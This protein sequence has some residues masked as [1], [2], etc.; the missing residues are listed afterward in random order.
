MIH[1]TNGHKFSQLETMCSHME[2]KKNGH[3]ESTAGHVPYDITRTLVATRLTREPWSSNPMSAPHRVTETVFGQNS[4]PYNCFAS[5][6]S[7][8]KMRN[9]VTHRI[10]F[11]I[12]RLVQHRR[13]LPLIIL[14]RSVDLWRSTVASSRPTNQSRFHRRPRPRLKGDAS[15]TPDNWLIQRLIIG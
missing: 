6:S 7:S 4:L 14:C 13:A 10:P 3:G 2:Q 5:A 15:A 12:L 11:V 8:T 1:V 9:I